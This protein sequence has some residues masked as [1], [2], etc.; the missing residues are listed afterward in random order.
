MF[1]KHEYGVLLILAV[2]AFIG[3]AFVKGGPT[4]AVAVETE[5]CVFTLSECTGNF[6]SLTGAAEGY[7][8]TTERTTALFGLPGNSECQNAIISCPTLGTA[9]GRIAG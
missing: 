7:G 2:V 3:L 9:T 5:P 4:G 6:I 8:Q 1:K